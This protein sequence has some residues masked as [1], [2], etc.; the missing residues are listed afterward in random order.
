MAERLKIA[1]KRSQAARYGLDEHQNPKL[2][3]LVTPPTKRRLRYKIEG[4]DQSR[5]DGTTIWQTKQCGPNCPHYSDAAFTAHD[6]FTAETAPKIL[7]TEGICTIGKAWKII[8]T[9]RPDRRI[10]SCQHTCKCTCGCQKI[11][12]E[13][14]QPCCNYCNDGYCEGQ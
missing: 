8:I 6:D 11:V 12:E 1:Q 5:W 14:L 3:P 2:P 13:P 7:L 10:R 4:H 9:N